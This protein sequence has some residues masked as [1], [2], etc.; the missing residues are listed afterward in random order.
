M[1][2]P[3]SSVPRRGS[4]AGSSPGARRLQRKTN[5]CV[6][7][8]R[9]EIGRE[10][11]RP[12]QKLILGRALIFHFPGSSHPLVGA[13]GESAGLVL[14]GGPGTGADAEAAVDLGRLAGQLFED[15]RE[16]EGVGEAGAGRDL[17]DRHAGAQQEGLG[18]LDAHLSQHRHGRSS[19]GP[20]ECMLEPGGAQACM[21]GDIGDPDSL[22]QMLPHEPVCPEHSLRQHRLLLPEQEPSLLARRREQHPD[23]KAKVAV[24][25]ESIEV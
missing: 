20:V 11:F 17:F 2:R 15:P 7:R 16:M 19:G 14:R 18:G 22:V 23:Q 5:P 6:A 21:G 3:E 24:P 4:P 10:H 12:L 13:R 9:P 25:G 8:N 1:G